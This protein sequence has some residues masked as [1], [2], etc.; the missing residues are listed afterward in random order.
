MFLAKHFHFFFFFWCKMC[1]FLNFINQMCMINFSVRFL[2]KVNSWLI[3]FTYL[4]IYQNTEWFRYGKLFWHSDY[5]RQYG[6]TP[7]EGH[8]GK[9]RISSLEH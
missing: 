3:E 5:Y 8:I 7:Q 1:A 2:F 4:L 9:P 6:P